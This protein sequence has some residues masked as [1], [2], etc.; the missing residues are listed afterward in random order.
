MYSR[1]IFRLKSTSIFF[2]KTFKQIKASNKRKI[3]STLSQCSTTTNLNQKRG[4]H[5]TKLCKLEGDPYKILGVPRDASASDIK[6]S[7]YKLAKK[8][9]PDVNKEKDADK[10]FNEI[11]EAY[12]ILSDEK[13][14]QQYDQFGSAAFN[15]GATGAE[16]PF[17][18]HPFGGQGNPFGGINF[19]DLFGGAF[20]DAFSGAGGTRGA[21]NGPR[22]YKE[23]KGSTVEISHTISFKDAVFGIKGLDLKFSAYD[24]CHTCSGSGL[25]EGSH[26]S[27]CTACHGTGTRV[28]IR[29]GFQM[30]STCNVCDGS[31]STINPSD[32]CG[33]CHGEGVVLNKERHIKVDL[34]SGVHDGDS[35]KVAG[36]GSYP[37]IPNDPETVKLYKGDILLHVHVERDARFKVKGKDI[38]VKQDIPITTAALGGVVVVPT[39]DGT[40]IRIRVPQGTQPSEV[41]SIPNMGV[42][43]TVGS[44]TRGNLKV[45]LN[46]VVKKPRSKA[47][48]CLLEALADVTNDT[49][50]K[51]IMTKNDF[52]N[53]TEKTLHETGQEHLDSPSA[54]SKIEKFISNAFK[55]ITGEKKE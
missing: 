51:R 22:Y 48:T 55:K 16:N 50:A 24:Q 12:D 3:P 40:Q 53:V 49:T 26:K 35:L 46:V 9:H 7:Y 43:Y 34:P 13:K 20:H 18:G 2:P 29:G 23:F 33:S 1:T 11:S 21:G 28:F 4:F 45:E 39:V 32:Y 52:D 25:K 15:G 10:T 41:I 36:V 14:R 8:H 31:G 19:D 27:T 44:T 37:H 47:E 30:S 42:P 38:W 17:G 54:L 5:S 6:K